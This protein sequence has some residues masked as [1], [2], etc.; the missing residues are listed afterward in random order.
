MVWKIRGDCT[1]TTAANKTARQDAVQSLINTYNV[2][3]AGGRYPAG[4][5]SQSTTRFTVSVNTDT[6]A[7]A[8]AFI[9]QLR[10]ALTTSS[11]STTFFCIF[12]DRSS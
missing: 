2:T 1:Y 3:P 5:V 6:Y 9:D 12:E 11:R 4:L 10:V 8:D 7:E